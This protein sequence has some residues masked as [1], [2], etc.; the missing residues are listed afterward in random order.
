MKSIELTVTNAVGLHA[1]PATLFVKAAQKHPA[2]IHV[3]YGDKTVS[4]KSLLALLTLAVGK[5]AVITVTAEG[6]GADAALSELQALVDT[7]FGE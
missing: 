6:E 3:T 7:N 1:R 5:D 4:A 2:E